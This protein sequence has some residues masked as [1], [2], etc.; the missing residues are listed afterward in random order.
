MDGKIFVDTSAWLAYSAPRETGHHSVSQLFSQIAKSRSQLITSNDVIDESVTRFNTQA[1]WT[2]THQLINYFNQAVYSKIL[3][4]V[5]TSE[6]IQSAALQLFEKYQ[7][8]RLSLTNATSAILMKKLNIKTILTL[9]SKH[10]TA[11]GF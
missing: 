5:W 2:L 8:H 6:P 10:F 1:G 4:L 11:L 9:D 7:D 3:K